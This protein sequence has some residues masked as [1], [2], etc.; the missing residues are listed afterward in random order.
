MLL[1][2]ANVMDV[3]SNDNEVSKAEIFYISDNEE[4]VTVE[5]GGVKTN[6]LIDSGASVNAITPE[7]FNIL[8]GNE[9]AKVFN[10][11][12]D[13]CGSL[14]AYASSSPLKVEAIFEANLW[15]DD[16]RPCDMEEFTVIN[17]AKRCLLSKE[18]SLKYKLLQV[19]LSVDINAI[20]S[21]IIEEKSQFPKFNL[22]PVILIV[23]E[24]VP[25]RRNIYTCIPP[26]WVTETRKRLEDQVKLGI[27]ER[28]SPEMD[29]RHC[30]SM[31]A[32]PKGSDDFRLVIDLRNPN[33]CIIREP[34]RMPTFDSVIAKLEGCRWFSTIDLKDAFHHVVLHEN[35]RHL[36]NFWSGDECFRCVRLPFGLCNAPDLFQK[37][38]EQVLEGCESVAIYLDDVLV[39]AKSEEEHDAKLAI[40]MKK[41]K[42]HSVQLSKEKCRFKVQ[43]CKFLGFDLSG[44]GYSIAE[45]KVKAIKNFKTPANLAELRSFIGLL[46]FVDRYIIKRAEKTEHLQGILRSKQF[47]WSKEAEEEFIFMRDHALTKIKQLGFYNS[48]HRTELI[49][50]ASPVGLGAVL[51]QINEENIPRIIACASKALTQT[52]SRYSQTQKEALA[53]VWGAERFRFFLHGL[54]F[55]IITDSE[56]NEYIYGEEFRLGRRAVSRAEAWAL[57][58]QSFDFVIVGIEGEK[59]IADVF[60]RLIKETQVAEPFVDFDVGHLMT[61]SDEDIQPLS[62]EEISEASQTDSEVIGIKKAL[63]TGVWE[64]EVIQFKSLADDLSSVGGLLVV[65]DKLFV[66]SKLR[67]KALDI[68]HRSHFGIN[69]MKRMLRECLWWPKMWKEIEDVVRNCSTCVRIGK[70]KAPIPL[71][72]RA[73]PSLP[74]Q[75]V[76][77]DF[78]SLPNC[79]SGKFFTVV[80]SYSRMLWC[81]EMNKTDVNPTIRALNR[82]FTIWG[83]PEVIQSDNGP[84]FNSQQFTAYWEKGGIKHRTVFPYAPF[85]NGLIERQN[86][87][88]IKA[89]KCAREENKNWRD[90]LEQYV[91]VYNNERP[92]ATS[93]VTPFELMTGRKYRGYFPSLSGLKNNLMIDGEVRDRDA[94]AKLKSTRYADKVRHA[95]SSDIE[96]G[97][98]V[99]L[100]DKNKVNKLSPTYLR[101]PFRVIK[102]MGP[103]VIVKNSDGAEYS[104]WISD[105]VKIPGSFDWNQLT[106]NANDQINKNN[107]LSPA[108]D[109]AGNDCVQSSGG[110]TEV[111]SEVPS[112]RRFPSERR[113]TRIRKIPAK[114]D[115]FKLYNIF[116]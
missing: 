7:Q 31:L 29:K 66:P 96:A 82:I 10:I 67:K 32:V 53:V 78:L 39:F 116:G 94:A 16:S 110:T 114:L 99:F 92:Q 52:E 11:R 102:K 70:P 93:G 108:K 37:A 76:Q 2:K 87:G 111:E 56:A 106:D 69:S 27:I 65:N 104:R 113:S 15:I 105:V 1:Q 21:P 97:D 13:R 95:K 18:T 91:N 25:P 83:R 63:L 84:P 14:W 88:I 112:E 107:D 47:I 41:L 60:S 38:M 12:T 73:L 49:V 30:S 36:T 33:K 90:A 8:M 59:N 100:A 55:T 3:E 86:E 26:G 45:E 4:C 89:V 6:V 74:M 24:T 62:W 115:A 46:N 35:S 75:V 40:V 22:P 98:W 103:G 68:A 9:Q 79:G 51:V 48:S 71:K 20:V 5:I 81:V 42:E 44:S 61:I 109:E 72:S 28:V 85:M 19:G 34:H 80:D 101:D 58:L 57:R 64:V 77:V 50:D 43:H 17:G 54:K 23:D